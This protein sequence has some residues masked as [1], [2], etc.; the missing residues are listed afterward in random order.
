MITFLFGLLIGFLGGYF[1]EQWN[2]TK[3]IANWL[4]KVLGKATK[5]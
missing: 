5:K 4:D 2:F 1:S 3:N